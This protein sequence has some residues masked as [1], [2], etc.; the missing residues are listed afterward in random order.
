MMALAFSG[1]KDSMACLH[2]MR[3]QLDC[4]IYVDTGYGYPETQAMVDYAATLLPVHRVRVDRAA[5]HRE[6]GLPSDIVPIN[7]TKIG[8]Q[9]TG[10]KR[11]MVQS[12]LQC[13]Y[14]NLARPLLNMAHELGVTYL[15]Y[16]QRNDE[17]HKNPAKDGDYIEGMVRVH[18][19]ETWTAQEV[20]GYLETKMDIPA[21]YAIEHS[22]LDCYDCTAYR[23]ESQDRLDWTLTAHPD[24]YHAYHNRAVEL[25]QC[26]EV[27]HG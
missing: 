15:V 6:N 14:E 25:E 21:H 26:L 22:S 7:W 17:T 1:G 27:A 5:Q 4:A 3:G 18:P 23:D 8:Q 24:F 9:M 13:C 20:L 11:T 10:P 16:G 2:L 19:I 12:Y